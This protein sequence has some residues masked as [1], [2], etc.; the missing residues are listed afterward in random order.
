VPI[1]PPVVKDLPPR[2]ENERRRLKTMM[3]V[4]LITLAVILVTGGIAVWRNG[5]ISGHTPGVTRTGCPPGS[6]T[7]GC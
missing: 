6:T 4:A 2:L 5:G 1:L 7:S 3:V